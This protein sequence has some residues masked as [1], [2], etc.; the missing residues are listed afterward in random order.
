MLKKVKHGPETGSTDH[1]EH[2]HV[3]LRPFRSSLTPAAGCR[4]AHSAPCGQSA[5]MTHTWWA[6]GPSSRPPN[7]PGHRCDSPALCEAEQNV[8][9]SSGSCSPQS[10][11]EAD[12]RSG[13]TTYVGQRVVF[14]GL[15]SGSEEVGPLYG[16]GVAQLQVLLQ[17]HPPR[18]HFFQGA[19]TQPLQVLHL[20]HHQTVLTGRKQSSPQFTACSL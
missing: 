2:L 11:S 19:Q 1:E 16:V 14:D 3:S 9:Y 5:D 6:P 8:S 7:T 12:K 13:L 4:V 17:T 15:V 10:C 18:A 20:Y